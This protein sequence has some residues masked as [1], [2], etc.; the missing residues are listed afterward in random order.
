MRKELGKIKKASFGLGGYQGAMIGI[1]FD[2]GGKGWGAGDT[3]S[4]WDAETVSHSEHS[5]WTEEERSTQYADIM[6]QVSKFL[7]DAKV[8]TVTELVGIPVEIIFDGNTLKEWRI[9]TEVI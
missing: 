5:K 9:L 2:L 6:R 8:S 7:S 4:A 1:H 3:I